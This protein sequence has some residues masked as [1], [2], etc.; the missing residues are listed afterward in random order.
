ML[1]PDKRGDGTA[2]GADARLGDS[3]EAMGGGRWRAGGEKEGNGENT[4][5]AEPIAVTLW[6][7]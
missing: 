5:H 7:E 3:G 1:V 2:I 4:R 6:R